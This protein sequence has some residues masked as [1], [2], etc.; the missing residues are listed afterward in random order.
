MYL[1]TYMTVGAFR[2]SHNYSLPPIESVA[3]SPTYSV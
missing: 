1:G 3:A 2:L